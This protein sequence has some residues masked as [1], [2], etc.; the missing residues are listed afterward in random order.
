MRQKKIKKDGGCIIGAFDQDELV[1]VASVE[2][3]KRGTSSSYCKMD[4]LYVSRNYREM[5]LGYKLLEKCKKGAK[6]FGV[7]KLY[8]SATPTKNTVDFYLRNGAVPVTELDAELYKI[9]PDDI[10]LEISIYD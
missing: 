10:Y 5:K 7:Q 6:G 3:E 4:I 1:G 2:K 8:I 9:E